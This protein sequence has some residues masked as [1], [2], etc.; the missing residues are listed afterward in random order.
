M[1]GLTLMSTSDEHRHRQRGQVLVLVAL[2]MVALIAMV[3]LVLDGGATFG[4]RRSEQRAADLSALAGANDFLL[5][6]DIASARTVAENVARDNGYDRALVTVDVTVSEYGNVGDN[7]GTVKVAITARHQNSFS[8][9]LGF[10]SWDVSASATAVTGLVTGGTGL[11]PMI[12]SIKDFQTNGQPLPNY[13]VSGVRP[14]R[15]SIP[16][17]TGVRSGPSTATHP[18]PA[19]TTLPGRTSV[20][21]TSTRTRF[22]TSSPART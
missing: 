17:R 7:A 21:A 10:N 12:F 13:T 2:G 19:A 20:R 15:G 22:T 18:P 8:T 11:G 1:K 6:G 5:H 14:Y 4:Q 16:R 3:G 9:I